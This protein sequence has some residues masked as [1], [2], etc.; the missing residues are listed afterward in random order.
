MRHKLHLRSSLSLTW[1]SLMACS[2]F[3]VTGCGGGGEELAT[4]PV[5]TEPL[6]V[7]DGMF[8][9][10]ASE[11]F[12]SCDNQPS[13]AGQYEF[14]LTDGAFTFGTN[15]SGT[16]SV[17]DSRATGETIRDS[18]TVRFCTT[19][20][21]MEITIRFT[22]EDEF[23]GQIKYRRRVDGDCNSACTTTWAVNGTRDVPT[24]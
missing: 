23:A 4:A 21:W 6:Q 18:N 24:P 22:S 7:A 15:L 8:T 3:L 11:I 19:T 9:I 13:P 5:D 16:W 2:L 20:T 17:S 14:K 12:D 1:V 10:T